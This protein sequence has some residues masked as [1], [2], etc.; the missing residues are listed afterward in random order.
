MV[1]R[2]LLQGLISA[3]LYR[4]DSI[5]FLLFLSQRL[6]SRVRQEEAISWAWE[7]LTVRYGLD[8]SRLYATYYRGDETVPED[9][10]ARSIW[11][12]FLPENRVLPFG[13]KVSCL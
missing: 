13:R 1:F 6:D 8:P 2:K 12:R 5:S 3:S 4:K 11:L 9:K 10:E 7:L